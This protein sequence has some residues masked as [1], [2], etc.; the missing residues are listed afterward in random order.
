MKLI[1][2]LLVLISILPCVLFAA[3]GSQAPDAPITPMQ[4]AEA[5][6][7][8]FDTYK[9]A[10]AQAVTKIEEEGHE[11]AIAREN[12]AKDLGHDVIVLITNDVEFGATQEQIKNN[13]L[14]A[15]LNNSSIRLPSPEKLTSAIRIAEQYNRYEILTDLFSRPKN[16]KDPRTYKS[17]Q[18]ELVH[19]VM[20]AQVVDDYH[21]K[22]QAFQKVIKEHPDLAKEYPELFQKLN[23]SPHQ[24]PAASYTK[25][26][27]ISGL[28][29]SGLSLLTATGS[30]IPTYVLA[31]RSFKRNLRSRL[32]ARSADRK[33][34]IGAYRRHAQAAAA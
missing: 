32:A 9:A 18:K 33:V 27:V 16:L 6:I 17:A 2:A 5:Y 34:L 30:A 11:A 26:Q 19:A 15:A 7:N 21:K 28:A 14:N 22:T 13:L 8:A 31:R 25:G 24:E 23:G 12:L 1:K 29:G 3:R 10:F 4:I 20:D